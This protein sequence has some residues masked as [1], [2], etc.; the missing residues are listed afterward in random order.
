MAFSRILLLAACA[1]GFRVKPLAEECPAVYIYDLPEL[2]DFEVPFHGIAMAE[3]D[4]VFGPRCRKGVPEERATDQYSLAAIRADIKAA[5]STRVCPRRTSRS[6][7]EGTSKIGRESRDVEEAALARPE[8]PAKLA[9]LT[10]PQAVILL[11]RLARDTRCA[12]RVY[13]PEKADLFYVPAY[14]TARRRI[15]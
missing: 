9:Q 11:W 2:Y 5:A 8:L 3:P 1:R 4:R 15:S 7:R 12:R 14:G 13:A 10:T 6:G